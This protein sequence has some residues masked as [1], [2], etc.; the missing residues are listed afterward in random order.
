[1]MNVTSRSDTGTIN[2]S[3][4]VLLPRFPY[5]L[6]LGCS[7][8]LQLNGQILLSHVLFAECRLT[9]AGRS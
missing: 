4:R 7:L 8:S 1:M 3:P 6:Q 2:R 9:E 5:A